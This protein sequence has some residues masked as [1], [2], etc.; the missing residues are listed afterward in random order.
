MTRAISTSAASATRMLRSNLLEI[1]VMFEKGEQFV[2][3]LPR[4]MHP[5]QLGASRS[6]GCQHDVIVGGAQVG[7]VG[8]FELMGCGDACAIT[9]LFEQAW[10]NHVAVRTVHERLDRSELR[11]FEA[12]PCLRLGHQPAICFGRMSGPYPADQRADGGALT[13]HCYQNHGE[14]GD[15]N[16][17]RPGIVSGSDRIGR[18]DAMV[19]SGRSGASFR[20]RSKATTDRLPRGSYRPL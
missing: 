7:R 12:S 5:Q 16:K 4:S 11:G 2:V 1:G 6:D 17:M 18:R 15:Q 14:S 8:G 20:L 9:V 3:D 19:G 10:M 13:E